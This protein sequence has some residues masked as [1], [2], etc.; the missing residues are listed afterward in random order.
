MAYQKWQGQS[1]CPSVES[2]YKIALNVA[3]NPSDCSKQDDNKGI[4]VFRQFLPFVIHP[5]FTNY[6]N[7]LQSINCNKNAFSITPRW[8]LFGCEWLIL[9][10]TLRQY[11]SSEEV[12]DARYGQLARISSSSRPVRADCWWMKRR[13]GW[14]IRV[15]MVMYFG[16][17]YW[18]P[19]VCCF[20]CLEQNAFIWWS[21]EQNQSVEHNLSKKW[22]ET[23]TRFRY[24]CC[25]AV[26]LTTLHPFIIVGTIHVAPRFLPAVGNTS[27]RELRAIP[28]SKSADWLQRKWKTKTNE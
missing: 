5:W 10:Y 17:V 7:D 14:V 28:D 16:I 8:P 1:N 3:N 18:L 19:N 24:C 9:F 27:C 15:T 11:S 4:N 13:S 25:I 21:V 6:T 12:C 22:E 2:Q 26:S 20:A 23:R